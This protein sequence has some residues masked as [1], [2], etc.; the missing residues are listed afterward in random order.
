MSST[1]GG[2]GLKVAAGAGLFVLL[3][4]ADRLVGLISISILARLL[5]PEAFGLVAL[6]TTVV[7]VIETFGEFGVDQALIRAQK[8]QRGDYD[9]AWSIN[10]VMGFVL[11]GVMV[12]A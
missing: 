8:A 2:L 12:A 1:G 3:R 6:A 4:V 9:S 11:A 7:A 10:V 5:T